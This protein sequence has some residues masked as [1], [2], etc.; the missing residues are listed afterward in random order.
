[1]ENNS[2]IMNSLFNYAFDNGI[3]MTFMHLDPY[4]PPA[5]NVRT[6]KILMNNNWHNKAELPIQLAHEIG[7]VML[8]QESSGLLYYTPSKFGMEFEANKYAV[9]LLLPFYME[10]K[11]SQQ[12]NVYD[13]IDCFSVPY[14]LEEAVTEAIRNY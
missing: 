3:S 4:T 1:M 8:E 2:E 9:N 13:F 11:E 7:H 5:T 14:H 6:K 12:V 10:D